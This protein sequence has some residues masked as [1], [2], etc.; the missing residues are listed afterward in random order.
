MRTVLL[1]CLLLP[2]HGT[3]AGI[4][5]STPPT[6]ADGRLLIRDRSRVLVYDLRAAAE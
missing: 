1:A 4:Q 5:L 6:I 3:T 2:R